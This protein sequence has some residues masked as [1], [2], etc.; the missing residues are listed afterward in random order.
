[1]QEGEWQA[2]GSGGLGTGTRSAKGSGEMGKKEAWVFKTR[3]DVF[4][5]FAFRKFPL[6]SGY[7]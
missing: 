4:T 2:R 7:M 5:K 6:V 3:S 1:V